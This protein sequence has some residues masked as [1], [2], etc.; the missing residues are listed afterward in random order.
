[1]AEPLGNLTDEEHAKVL[2]SLDALLDAQRLIERAAELLSPVPGF[3]T[4]W[5]GI[6]QL[7]DEVKSHWHAVD[8]SRA[9]VTRDTGQID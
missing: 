7:Y 3:A 1:M 8:K 5:D 9:M 4:E 6:M 2:R